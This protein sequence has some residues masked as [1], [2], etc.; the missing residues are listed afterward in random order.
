MTGTQLMHPNGAY[1]ANG[2]TPRS[3]VSERS[4]PVASQPIRLR[5]YQSLPLP[6]Y[7]CHTRR[8]YQMHQPASPRKQTSIGL[9]ITKHYQPLP[10][11]TW[12]RRHGILFQIV[13]CPKPFARW[14]YGLLSLCEATKIIKIW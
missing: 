12:A 11:D 1:I 13:L 5:P 4:C 8:P 6:T 9:H 14:S 7:P 10:F 3:S 2:V